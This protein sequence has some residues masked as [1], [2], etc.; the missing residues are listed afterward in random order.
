MG[1]LGRRE[2]RR[3]P[4]PGWSSPLSSLRA[5]RR[6]RLPAPTGVQG[7]GEPA[8]GAV[9][10]GGGDGLEAALA[11]S[12]DFTAATASATVEL[13]VR[14]RKELSEQ[15]LDAGPGTITW[16]LAHHHRLTV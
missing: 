4:G 11:T 8:P 12:Q 3:C 2:P 1:T 5:A 10:G 14:L 9:S 7:L 16:H 6:P 13:I 15:G